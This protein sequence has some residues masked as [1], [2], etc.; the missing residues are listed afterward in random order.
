MVHS[1]D[2]TRGAAYAERH[3]IPD[4]TTDL[5]QMLGNPEIGAVYIS[6]TN[7]KHHPQAMAAIAAGERVLCEKPL[8]MTAEAA[9]MVQAAEAKGMIFS[10][11][12]I[13]FGMRA[14]T[15]PSVTSSPTAG[16]GRC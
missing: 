1:G 11:P 15:W 2:A 12:T 6:T 3:A 10:G 16:S 7:D 13:I 14:R 5:Q 8:A 9:E 4:S